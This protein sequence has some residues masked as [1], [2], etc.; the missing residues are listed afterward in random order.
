M[1]S[2][3]QSLPKAAQ[4]L[5]QTHCAACH[6]PQGEGGIGPTL[7][8]PKLT[9]ATTDDVLFK[10]LKEGIAGTEMPGSRLDDSE[11]RQLVGWVRKLGQTPT[12]AVAG[13]AARGQRLYFDQGNC[14]AC[15]AINGSGSAFGPDLSDIGLRRGAQHLRTSLLDPETDVPK[16]FLVYRPGTSI[17][18]NFLHVRVVTKDGQRLTGVRV[19]EDTFSIQ[20]RE[21]SGRVQSFFKAELRELHKDWGKS[22]M[23]SYRGVFTA[24]ELTDLIAFLVSLRGE[25]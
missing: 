20:L 21:Q 15:H 17:L 19:N 6:G 12:E 22:P 8:V 25:R 1:Y 13:D 5:Y 7:A 9:R 24:E 11:L 4:D 2:R 18:E 10:I 16:S 3:E 23:P 14:A